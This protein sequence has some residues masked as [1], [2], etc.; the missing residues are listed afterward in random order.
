MLFPKVH[1]HCW[2]AMAKS[3]L[4]TPSEVTTMHMCVI[5]WSLWKLIFTAEKNPNPWFG[6][7]NT[8]SPQQL[9]LPDCFTSRSSATKHLS[10][11]CQGCVL[12]SNDSAPRFPTD[13]CGRERESEWW[14]VK[15]VSQPLRL[16]PISR[17][18]HLTGDL[19]GVAS[20][21]NGLTWQSP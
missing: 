10:L 13:P 15:N 17:A 3:S 1:V 20:S 18:Q 14:R 9:H 16:V 19:Q 11:C 7:S 6:N 5:S 12:P 4:P 8:H 21:K 2:W